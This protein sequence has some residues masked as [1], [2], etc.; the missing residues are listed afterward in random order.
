MIAR[1]ADELRSGRLA[2]T[3]LPDEEEHRALDP[4]IANSNTDDDD[5]EAPAALEHFHDPSVGSQAPQISKNLQWKQSFS[6]VSYAQAARS[7]S[8]S[9]QATNVRRPSDGVSLLMEEGFGG[10]TAD[11]LGPPTA[12]ESGLQPLH[13]GY[14]KAV[15]DYIE[16]SMPSKHSGGMRTGAVGNETAT[17]EA[18]TPVFVRTRR[19]RQVK[20]M[21]TDCR[22]RRIAVGQT[23]TPEN[24]DQRSLFAQCDGKQPCANC[25]RRYFPGEPK[26]EI[27]QSP[28]LPIHRDPE[29]PAPSKA[30][31]NEQAVK[32]STDRKGSGL[33]GTS[34]GAD[35][36]R[37]PPA[38][39]E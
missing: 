29:T 1:K 12:Q 35:R 20:P 6:Q 30:P 22:M 33:S 25:K 14:K 37:R 13:D 15:E 34:S 38:R 4:N 11:D 3:R 31:P 26:C 39:R 32:R 28:E 10:E 24:P 23:V 8:I 5:I 16:N 36:K 18:D 2:S 7:Q 19:S 9:H 27:Y 17:N 21:C